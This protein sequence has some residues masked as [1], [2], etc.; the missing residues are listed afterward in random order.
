[1]TMSSEVPPKKKFAEVRLIRIVGRAAIAA[2]YSAP[3]NV[4]RARIRSRNSAVG[5][6]GLTPGENPAVLA[7]VVGLV[8]RVEGHRGVEVGEEDDQDRLADDVGGLA[9]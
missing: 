5:R 9:R 4:R 6:P 2:R 3:G 1:M 7:Q 8:D